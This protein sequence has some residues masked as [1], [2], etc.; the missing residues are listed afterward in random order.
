MLVAS[1]SPDP[2]EPAGAEPEADEAMDQLRAGL[3]R[4]RV[5]VREARQAIGQPPPD[6]PVLPP[7]PDEEGP[8]IPAE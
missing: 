6:G 3:R 4:A 7:D 5:I 8:V 2:E 1:M